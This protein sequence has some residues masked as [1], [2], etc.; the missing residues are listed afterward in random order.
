MFQCFS[1]VNDGLPNTQ[2]EPLKYKEFRM[3]DKVG[4]GG[5]ERGGY[6]YY[7]PFKIWKQISQHSNAKMNIFQLYY[8]CFESHFRSLIR[9]IISIYEDIF[10]G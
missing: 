8:N 7:K 4:V 5:H 2:N 6:Y 3:L 10:L 1:S 9:S